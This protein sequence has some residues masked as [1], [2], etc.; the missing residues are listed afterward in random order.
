MGYQQQ[1][2]K[3][4]II[5]AVGAVGSAFVVVLSVIIGVGGSS[6]AGS[7]MTSAR[8]TP[9]STT[10]TWS[11]STSPLP[12]PTPQ[13]TISCS[14][15]TTYTNRRQFTMDVGGDFAPVW[16]AAPMSCEATREPGTLTPI[17]QQAFTA[18]GY[19]DQISIK[20]LY[21]LCASV[22]PNHTYVSPAHSLSAN[23]IPEVT[24]MLTLCPNHPQASQLHDA[25]TRGQADA[26][27]AAA[28]ELFYSGTFLVNSEIPPGTYAAEGE[29]TNCYWE[30][31]DAKGEIIDNNF[32]TGARRVEVTVRASDY[33][34]HNEGCG[35]WRKVR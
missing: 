6:N 24:G 12:P 28:G 27:A 4:W 7:A 30:R 19:T 11:T 15:D 18:S 14:M 8:A 17:E 13:V 20:T 35:Q 5:V 2:S 32:V 22:N 10:T 16:G 26:A 34:F 3:R 25:I 31:T 23:Q 29:I 21:G 33:S 9:T 1:V